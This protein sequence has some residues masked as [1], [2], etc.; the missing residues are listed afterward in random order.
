MGE[1]SNDSV[2]RQEETGRWLVQLMFQEREYFQRDMEIYWLSCSFAGRQ[3]GLA[4][5]E[6]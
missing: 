2:A 1:S 6:K 5:D 3:V 4:N